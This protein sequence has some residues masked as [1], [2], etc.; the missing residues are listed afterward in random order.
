MRE[1]FKDTTRLRVNCEEI[2]MLRYAKITEKMPREFL[3][4]QGTGCK[5][6]QCTFCDYHLDVS[7]HPFEINRTVLAQVT[8]QYGVLDIINSGSCCELDDNTI[9]CI[10]DVVTEK[11]IHTL[12]FEAHW[13]YRDKLAEFAARFPSTAVKFRTGVETFD[14][15]LRQTWKK[16][17]PASVSVQDIAAYFQGICLLFGI[18]GQTEESVSRDIGLALTH[19]E[20]A[21]INAFAEN[22]TDVKKNQP[23]IDWFTAVCYEKLRAHPKIEILLLNTDLGVG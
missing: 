23:L 7:E 6:K 13:M 18:S 9:A 15:L 22:T 12:W 3:L 11:G 4:L 10:E 17:I 16:G 5:W 20:Y 19:F 1:D 8:G 21:S 2:S 14:P